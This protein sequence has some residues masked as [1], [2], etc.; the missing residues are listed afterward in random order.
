MNLVRAF[1]SAALV[2]GALTALPATAA[3][4]ATPE[5][6]NADLAVSFHTRGAA[7]GS[8]YGVLRYRNV[9]GHACWTG[10]YGGVS[11]VGHHD[12]TQ[13]GAAAVRAPGTP[14]RAFVLK[15][16][17]R[18]VSKVQIAQSANY[19]KSLCRP[20]RADGFRVY[21][22]DSDASQFVPY[23]TRACS[24]SVIKTFSPQ[25]SHQALK[26]KG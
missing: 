19:D 13:L 24:R 4:A 23:Q 8:L 7:A 17:Q 26:K 9:S 5:C 21:V 12:G 10:G 1:F 11:F 18:A 15:P 6:G 14:V 25:L 2:G 20:K 16:G 22:P 3:H